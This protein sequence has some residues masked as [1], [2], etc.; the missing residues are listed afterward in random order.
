MTSYPHEEKTGGKTRHTM[1]VPNDISIDRPIKLKARTRILIAGASGSIG[2]T[3]LRLVAQ[4]D[5]QIG[6]HYF[7]NDEPIY[8]TVEDC[9][10]PSSRVATFKAN[11][12][13]ETAAHQLIESFV[14][15]SGGIDVLIQLSGDLHRPV[16]W[17]DMTEAD[18]HADLGVNLIGPFFLA[19]TAMKHMKKAE[20]PGRIILTGTASASHGGGPTTLAYGVAKAGIEC[21]AK[22]L[23]K[24]GAPDNILVNAV[25]PGF[26]N[27]SFHTQRARRTE[28][29]LHRRAEMVPLHR[30]GTPNEVAAL[31]AF[32]A[33][34][35][36]SF[37]TGECIAVSGGDF[38]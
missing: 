24:I 29:E 8:R 15:W 30:P 31:I 38:L 32:L 18:W 27:T 12:C 20:T 16:A 6:A 2:T 36:A 34:P 1:T 4:N 7:S 9:K 21:L 22:G 10:I 17:D 25:C 35:S 37:I 3:V 5:I 11:L 26:I 13:N 19:Q 33:S 23:A 28:P 14:A